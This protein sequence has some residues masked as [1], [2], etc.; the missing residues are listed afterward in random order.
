M[1]ITFTSFHAIFFFEIDRKGIETVGN[2]D[3][4]NLWSAQFE[5]QTSGGYSLSLKTEIQKRDRFMSGLHLD[6]GSFGYIMSI[7][8]VEKR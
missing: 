2:E 7:F 4:Q 6:R 3:N 5:N 1:F 8:R